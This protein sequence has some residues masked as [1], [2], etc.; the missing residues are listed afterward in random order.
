MANTYNEET[1]GLDPGETFLFRTTLD[2]TNED[3]AYILLAAEYTEG[4]DIESV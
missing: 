4:R 1:I 2:S 3:I